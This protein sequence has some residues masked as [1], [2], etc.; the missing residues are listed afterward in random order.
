MDIASSAAAIDEVL[1][2]ECDPQQEGVPAASP[3]ALVHKELWDT[4]LADDLIAPAAP[5]GVISSQFSDDALPLRA[6]FCGTMRPEDP[7]PSLNPR[8]N[9]ILDPPLTL[10]STPHPKQAGS[11]GMTNMTPED[12]A[13]AID[14][15]GLDLAA[16][17]RV[18]SGRGTGEAEELQR[19]MQLRSE[20]L[21]RLGDGGEIVLGALPGASDA[22]AAGSPSD[23][24]R[25][26]WRSALASI[27]TLQHELSGAGDATEGIAHKQ[28]K[29]AAFHAQ[30]SPTLDVLG[31]VRAVDSTP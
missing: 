17:R 31:E 1:P 22:A 29:I 18:A 30:L 16:R 26:L 15:L 28:Q 6:S 24:V 21:R 12:L 5:S 4:F 14:S 2:V 10:S 25:G 3:A 9:A 20:E 8:P 19:E 13:G 27:S 7:S 11:S 23:A